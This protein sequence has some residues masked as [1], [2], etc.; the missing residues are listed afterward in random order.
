MA[1]TSAL[2]SGS[3]LDLTSLLSQMITSEKQPQ[4]DLITQKTTKVSTTI[5]ALGALKSAASSFQTALA[6][7]KDPKFFNSHTATSGDTSMF[8]VTAEGTADAGSYSISVLNL[9]SANKIASGSF[10][11]PDAEVGT[12]KLSIGVGDETFDVDITSDNNS[13]ADI[14]DAINNAPNNTGVKASLLTISDG[15]GGTATKLVL[16]AKDTGAK[17]QISISAADDDGNNTD[18]SGLSQLYYSKSDEANSHF[19]EVK[20]ALDAQITIDGFAATSSTNEFKDS[21]TGVTITALKPITDSDKNPTSADLNVAVDTNS[22]KTAI[23]KFVTAYNA[24]AG[25]YNMMTSYTPASGTTTAATAGP[26]LGNSSASLLNNRMRQG[27]TSTVADAAPNFNSLASV[28]ITTKADGTLEIDDAKLS[29]ALSGNMDD[30]AKLF[31]GDNGVAGR[32]DKQLSDALSSTGLFQNTQNTLQSQLDDLQK[33]ATDLDT[34]MAAKEA[35]Y[36]A[37][38]TALDTLVA[39]LKQTGSFLTQQLSSM[40][41]SSSN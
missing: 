12:G 23:Q 15:A 20:P 41:S 10:A 6:D 16:T 29:K 35:S 34:R 3:G 40:N 7:L 13:L 9:A 26:L 30:V 1:T 8:S 32:L 18:G 11:N 2:G 4:I 24:Y 27:L 5:S 31:S 37:Q 39:Q 19:S 22:I 36:R 25:T 38:F 33:Q 14:R 21:I 28:G 17:S